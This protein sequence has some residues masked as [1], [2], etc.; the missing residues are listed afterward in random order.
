MNWTVKKFVF[1][2]SSSFAWP[3][4]GS[5]SWICVQSFIPFF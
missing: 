5:C 1:S 3:C 4:K 2:N